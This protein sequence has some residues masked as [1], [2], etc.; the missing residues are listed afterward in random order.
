MKTLIEKMKALRIYA[1]IYWFKK[2]FKKE[3]KNIPLFV[4]KSERGPI[5]PPIIFDSHSE[6]MEYFRN[7]P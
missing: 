2:L 5:N 6:A 3:K 1:V 4:V 7:N